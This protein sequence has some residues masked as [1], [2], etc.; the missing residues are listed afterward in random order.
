MNQTL[1]KVWQIFFKRDRR[2]ISLWGLS[3]LLALLSLALARY[4]GEPEL[5]YW[6]YFFWLFIIN[7]VIF[8]ALYK[9]SP[10]VSLLILALIFCLEVLMVGYCFLIIYTT[11]Y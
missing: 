7:S 4:I 6:R 11:A 1:G 3:L 9:S 8:W 2:L 5:I 10:V